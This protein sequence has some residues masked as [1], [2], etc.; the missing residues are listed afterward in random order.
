LPGQKIFCS[1]DADDA[2][3]RE[4]GTE[5]LHDAEAGNGVDQ[6]GKD[7]DHEEGSPVAELVAE[8]AEP[9]KTDDRPA[10]EVHQQ[11]GI[12]GLVQYSLK[13]RMG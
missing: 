5:Q 2:L 6:D 13:R 4:V 7:G 1:G 8:F 10:H 12:M 11:E 9:D 3:L